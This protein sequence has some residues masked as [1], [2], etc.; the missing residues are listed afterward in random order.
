MKRNA[1]ARIVIYSLL[2]FV[3][4]ALLAT[5][6]LGQNWVRGFRRNDTVSLTQIGGEPEPW[7]ADEIDS[8]QIEWAMGDIVIRT[9]DTEEIQVVE[10]NTG[11][12]D[13]MVMG[14]R[15]G[16]LII[17][18]W[19]RQN[20]GIGINRNIPRKNLYITVPQGWVGRK[21]DFDVAK[22]DLTLEN[23]KVDE[24]DF[25]GADVDFDIRSCTIGTLDVDT[26]SGSVSFTGSLNELDMDGAST[27]FT[28]EFDN[29]PELL[30]MDGMSGSLD[31]TLPKD[32]GFTATLDG[33]SCRFR[34]DL[35]TAHVNGAYTYGD[36]RCKIDADGMSMSVAV[37]VK[38]T[39]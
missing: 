15:N 28:G 27:D 31:V 38:E 14:A 37:K 23:L 12:A 30:K 35:A 9:G 20:F 24:V 19:Q 5:V 29:V 22:G 2:I 13:S 34:S 3:L 16:K 18:F 33:M 1:I 4:L 11:N 8:I 7:P 10:E 6:L 17:Q 39:P 36:G 32:A 26:A 25:D 21:L